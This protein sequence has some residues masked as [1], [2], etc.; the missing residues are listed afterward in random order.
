MAIELVLEA[1][2]PNE[3]RNKINNNFQQLETDST[4]ALKSN[5]SVKFTGSQDADGNRIMNMVTNPDNLGDAANV[6]TVRLYSDRNIKKN[7]V[8][9]SPNY[10][11]QVDYYGQDGTTVIAYGVKSLT[12]AFSLITDSTT[13]NWW[14]ISVADNE[15]YYSDMVDFNSA[16]DYIVI[17][18][19]GNTVYQFTGDITHIGCTKNMVLIT[20]Q[21]NTNLGNQKLDSNII[22]FSRSDGTNTALTLTQFVVGTNNMFVCNTTDSIILGSLIGTPKYF[23]LNRNDMS[24]D[25]IGTGVIDTGCINTISGDLKERLEELNIFKGL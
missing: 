7:H 8:Y 23:Y 22:K 12:E 9:V 20:N 10:I 25:N 3:G 19:E 1:D 13:N 6:A 11:T 18:G 21:V 24:I 2:S 4:T 15:N 16:P 17:E 14:T 5:G